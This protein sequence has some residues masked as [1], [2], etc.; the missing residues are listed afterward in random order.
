M[1]KTR[2]SERKIT[3]KLKSGSHSLNP[4]RVNG[5]GGNNMRTK[6]TIDRLNMYKNFKA[7]RN[8]KGKIIKAAPNQ[9]W[10]SSGTRA[11]VEPNRKWFANSRVITQSALQTFQDEIGK[12]MNDPYQMVLRPT[13]LPVKILNEKSK[14]E[15]VHLLEFEPFNNTFG[16]KAQR[17]RPQLATCDIN[18]S[19]KSTTSV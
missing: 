4:N 19:F 16:P 3:D 8:K 13:N 11:R 17:K 7:V 18:V 6:A 12:A 2:P 10:N 1:G 9:T 5:K 14:N 15:R